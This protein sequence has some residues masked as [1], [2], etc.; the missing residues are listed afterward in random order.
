MIDSMVVTNLRLPR[1]E[2]IMVRSLAAEAGISVN[3]FV[4]RMIVRFSTTFQL[5]SPSIWDL[6]K[7]ASGK[8]RPMGLSAEDEEIYAI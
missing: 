5:K 7:L 4:R 8:D 6:P 3:E 2:W 1:S